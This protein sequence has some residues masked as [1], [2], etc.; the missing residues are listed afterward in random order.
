V[1]VNHVVGGLV[2]GPFEGGS[3]EEGEALGVVRVFVAVRAVDVVAIEVRVVAEEDEA[4]AAGFL[5]VST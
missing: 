3:S 5:D 4:H 1:G 2:G